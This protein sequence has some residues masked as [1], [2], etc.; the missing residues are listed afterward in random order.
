[1]AAN[2]QARQLA[3]NRLLLGVAWSSSALPMVDVSKRRAAG[4][5]YVLYLRRILKTYRRSR[6][7]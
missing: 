4:N 5:A 2:Q 1:V 3:L 6:V 7:A